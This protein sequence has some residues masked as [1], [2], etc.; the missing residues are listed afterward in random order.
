MEDSNFFGRTGEQH[1]PGEFSRQSRVVGIRCG[2]SDKF[3]VRHKDYFFLYS[4]Q[5]DPEIGK[6]PCPVAG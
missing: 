3:V 5:A 6:A 4:V 2:L 1:I